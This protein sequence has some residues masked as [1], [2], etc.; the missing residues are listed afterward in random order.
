MLTTEFELFTT[1]IEK[2][3]STE[4]K[5]TGVSASQLAFAHIARYRLLTITILGFIIVGLEIFFHAALL[6]HEISSLRGPLFLIE[7]C[8]QLILFLPLGLLLCDF[9][10]HDTP[11]ATPANDPS[12]ITI[13][14]LSQLKGRLNKFKKNPELIIQFVEQ[15]K[16]LNQFHPHLEK[17]PK[18]NIFSNNLFRPRVK[19]HFRQILWSFLPLIGMVILIGTTTPLPGL[20][21]LIMFLLTASLIVPWV[22]SC[23]FV[24]WRTKEFFHFKIFRASSLRFSTKHGEIGFKHT[25]GMYF[26]IVLIALQICFS[27]TMLGFVFLIF[28]Q[29]WQ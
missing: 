26:W 14:A 11:I 12:F 2:K 24:W 13:Y 3:I 17:E 5:Q 6:N 28:N 10:K 4:L 15:S 18:E 9:Y 21:P 7:I 25:L 8:F 29:N 27:A 20:R 22:F 19:K 1:Q 16:K 23:Q